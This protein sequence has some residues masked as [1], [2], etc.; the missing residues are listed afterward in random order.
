M[1][2]FLDD[3]RDPP[4]D[5]W[6]R[7]FTAYEVIA[8][9][10]WDSNYISELSL[11]HDLGMGRVGTGMDVVNYMVESY[12]CPPVVIIHSGNTIAAK[13]MYLRLVDAFPDDDIR[14]EPRLL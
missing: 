9:L 10:T 2:V 7:V 13:E 3:V 12:N 1:K 5:S 14:L 11:D 8:M 4:D 6:R